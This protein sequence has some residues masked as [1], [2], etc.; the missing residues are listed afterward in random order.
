MPYEL[1]SSTYMFFTF[2]IHSPILKVKKFKNSKMNTQKASV[3]INENNAMHCCNNDIID[4]LHSITYSQY[5]DRQAR[6]S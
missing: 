3:I 1:K 5:G 4:S 2:K 6:T